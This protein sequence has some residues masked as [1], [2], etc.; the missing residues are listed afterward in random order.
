MIKKRITHSTSGNK[1]LPACGSGINNCNPKILLPIVVVNPGNTTYNK[2][3]YNMNAAPILFF[4]EDV[5]KNNMIK[6]SRNIKNNKLNSKLKVWKEEY[7]GDPVLLFLSKASII[8]LLVLK[9]SLSK[10]THVNI[11]P[12]TINGNVK[13]HKG[14]L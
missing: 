1:K 4:F 13:A 5:C 3:R 8:K 7:D 10:S 11:N 12:I 14:V 9:I 2:N 6:K